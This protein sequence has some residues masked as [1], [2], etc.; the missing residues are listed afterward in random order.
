MKILLAH[1]AYAEETF[2]W[3][4]E[5]AGAAGASIEATPFVLT[6]NPPAP[7]LS[8]PELDR[9]WNQ[10]DRGLLKMYEELLEAAAQCDVLLNYNGINI[11][12]EFLPSLPTFNVFA[13]FDDPENSANLSRPVA[14][15]YDAVFYG[16]IASRF[17]Y[18]SW[19][20]EK[21][22][23]L[24][25]FTNPSETPAPTEGERLFQRE[26]DVHIAFVGGKT[27]WRKERLEVL[28]RAFPQAQ[29]RG[30][31]W[32]SGN[33]GSQELD[34][35][36]R[37]ARIGWN[38][39]NSTGPINMRTFALAAYGILQICDN[40]TGLGQIFRLGEEAIGFDTIPEAIELTHYYLQHNEEARQIAQNAYERYWQEYHAGA[41]W[42]RIANQLAEWGAFDS[43]IAG[44]SKPLH[45]SQRPISERVSPLVRTVRSFV[46]RALWTV[47]PANS[48]RPAATAVP[49]D[50]SVY[51]ERKIPPMSQTPTMRR[52]GSEMGRAASVAMEDCPE[53]QALSWAVT[54]LI[55]DARKIVEIGS[56]GGAFAQYASVVPG[57]WIDCFGEDGAWKDKALELQHHSNVRYF[58]AFEDNLGEKYD[59]L[60]SLEFIQCAEDLRS[61][62]DFCAGL[63]PRAIF[64]AHNR[65]LADEKERMAPLACLPHVREFA[66]GELFWALGMFYRQVYLYYL[67][68]AYVPWIEPMRVDSSGA[69][70]IAECIGPY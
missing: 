55:G 47:R 13:C 27:Q 39:H 46:G 23:W 44:R 29:C 31:G 70:V 10:R 41:I 61:F 65:I 64:T 63:A 62:L 22:A 4:R 26:R 69:P 12:P 7:A 34:N 30:E 1:A 68:D 14:A 21:L 6:L 32:E 45:R 35:L 51:L 56:N 16:N 54:A 33:I 25:I 3:Y 2:K 18:E 57:R 8:W 15:S 48:E 36:Y 42:E 37:R 11:H 49:I 60:I 59:L 19:G 53:Y 20:C 5:I 28:S 50:E 38:V 58:T 9:L 67:P 66:P 52:E 40:K 43:K 24:P 17:Q